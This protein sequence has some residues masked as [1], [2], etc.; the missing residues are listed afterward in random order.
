MGD[1]GISERHR[2]REREIADH[3][4]PADQGNKSRINYGVEIKGDVARAGAQF[5][6]EENDSV[7]EERENRKEMKMERVRVISSVLTR[8]PRS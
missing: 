6:P 2:E 4:I 1:D 5:L 3:A 8:S 7:A